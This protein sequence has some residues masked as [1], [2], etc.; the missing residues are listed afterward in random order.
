MLAPKR[1]FL[2]GE[3]KWP[4]WSFDAKVAVRDQISICI[5]TCSQPKWLGWRLLKVA[6]LREYECECEPL[7]TCTALE[8]QNLIPRHGPASSQRIL[9]DKSARL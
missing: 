3:S 1:H 7:Y 5:W 4:L 8:G 2:A 9:S 6:R